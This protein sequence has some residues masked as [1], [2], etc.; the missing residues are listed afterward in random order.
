MEQ[1]HEFVANFN[2]SLDGQLSLIAARQQELTTQRTSLQ[3]DQATVDE[4]ALAVQAIALD[5][6]AYATAFQAGLS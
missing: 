4:E 5:E 1:F 3:R 2:E 6:A